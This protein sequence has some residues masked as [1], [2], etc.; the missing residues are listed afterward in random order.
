MGF[1]TDRQQGQYYWVAIVASPEWAP[2]LSWICGW[3]SLIGWIFLTSMAASFPSS[4]IVGM[5]GVMHPVGLPLR[6]LCVTDEY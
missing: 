3:V 6:S 1:P 2:L 4:M 5:A